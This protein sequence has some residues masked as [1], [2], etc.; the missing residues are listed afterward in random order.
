MLSRPQF[1]FTSRRYLQFSFDFDSKKT[2]TIFCILTHWI[3]CK[4]VIC[5][6]NFHL[7]EIVL[8]YSGGQDSSF[9][10]SIKVKLENNFII[11]KLSTVTIRRTPC[12][13]SKNIYH[14]AQTLKKS[15]F[16]CSPYLLRVS[17]VCF[18]LY[19]WQ[20]CPVTQERH[21][22]LSINEANFWDPSL[23]K[24]TIKQITKVNCTIC[25][26]QYLERHTIYCGLC[27]L[28]IF[29]QNLISQRWNASSKQY[30]TQALPDKLDRS[31]ILSTE[32]RRSFDKIHI[33]YA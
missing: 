26:Q 12:C 11:R 25:T 18:A 27:L 20:L 13:P 5:D 10:L 19:L 9:K 29:V 4:W 28:L 24:S 22:S 6:L 33:K 31:V 32:V 7:M 21:S 8:F 23:E 3:Y 16:V 15:L 2:G 14:I 1:Y 17:V 30:L